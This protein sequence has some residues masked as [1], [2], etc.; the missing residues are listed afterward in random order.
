MLGERR[1]RLLPNGALPAVRSRLVEL[2]KLHFVNDRHTSCTCPTA[3]STPS[4]RLDSLGFRVAMHVHA[5]NA[6]KSDRR[7]P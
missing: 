4:R 2:Q 3:L 5:M 6:R 7:G 1:L